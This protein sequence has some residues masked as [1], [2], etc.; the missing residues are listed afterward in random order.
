MLGVTRISDH[1]TQINF[2]SL[3]TSAKYRT[4]LQ[5]ALYFFSK[6]TTE[7]LQI[8]EELLC[9]TAHVAENIYEIT[10]MKTHFSQSH[11][12]NLLVNKLTDPPRWELT[13]REKDKIFPSL[14]DEFSTGIFCT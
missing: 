9:S 6:K 5:K 3:K 1:R 8:W 7:I 13:V 12:F 2:P 14:H 10:M 4:F 11:N